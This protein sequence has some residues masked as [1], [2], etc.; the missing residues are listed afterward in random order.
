MSHHTPS[1]APRPYAPKVNPFEVN[2]R[3]IQADIPAMARL[4]LLLI[5]DHARHGA[6]VCTASAATLSQ[7]LRCTDR[8]VRKL[9]A[10]LHEAGWVEI[11]RRTKSQHSRRSLKPSRKC[12]DCTRNGGSECA[13]A[14]G[15]IIPMHPEQPFR[16]VGTAVP[17]KVSLK[18]QEKEKN[19]RVGE[20]TPEPQKPP[21]RSCAIAREILA[22]PDRE[23]MHGHARAHL[24][25]CKW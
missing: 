20:E 8:E 5:L 3:V 25:R 17:C 10:V 19:S 7:E 24:E 11:V 14:P 13:T 2:R 22:N 4:L 16:E 9:V 21:C 18:S 12:L 23:L 15:T 6:S 1:R